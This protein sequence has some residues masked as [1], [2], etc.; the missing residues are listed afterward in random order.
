MDLPT[1]II[2]IVIDFCH[3]SPSALSAF[4]QTASRFKNKSQRHLFYHPKLTITWATRKS[5]PQQLRDVLIANPSLALLVKG[6]S[7][8]LEFNKY[9]PPG[10]TSV[11]FGPS[12]YKPGHLCDSVLPILSRLTQLQTL[13]VGVSNDHCGHFAIIPLQ[14]GTDMIF[15][16]VVSTQIRS[17]QLYGAS[18]TVPASFF[19]K[20]KNLRHWSVRDV[21]A[22]PFRSRVP[23]PYPHTPPATAAYPVDCPP[24]RLET[25]E[26]VT[27]TNAPWVVMEGALFL[28]VLLPLTHWSKYP[29]TFKTSG[30]R[31]LRVSV[32][33]RDSQAVL[34]CAAAVINNAASHLE[35]LEFV[36]HNG[37]CT[38]GAFHR[39]LQRQLINPPNLP[40]VA[41]RS[42]RPNVPNT[43]RY[44]LEVQPST[45]ATH[46]R[47]LPTTSEI[48]GEMVE[49]CQDDTWST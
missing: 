12:Q 41:S 22:S 40:P 7:F 26:L 38:I 20:Q 43:S 14:V 36:L 25:L 47:V 13:C 49:S 44:S 11:T 10:K 2:E 30:L 17:V 8:D 29:W 4:S 32:Q 21:S 19:V 35:R 23:L 46:H 6:I 3:N 27:T 24:A 39:L 16:S 42:I 9:P 37:G 34:S 45:P 5:P 15:H 31:A 33:G 28:D 18:L 48:R 1:E